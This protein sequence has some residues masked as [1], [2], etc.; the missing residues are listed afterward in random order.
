MVDKLVILGVL[1]FVSGILCRSFIFIPWS[2]V[3]FVALLSCV[4]FLLYS[5]RRAFLYLCIAV[6]L[7]GT[8]VGLARTE[9]APSDLPSVFGNLVGTEQS[10]EGRVITAPDV[11]ETSNRI[12]VEI[13]ED[14]IRTRLLAVAPLYPEVRL[15]DRV[16]VSGIIERPE[17]FTTN[18]ERVFNYDQFLIKEGIFLIIQ[19]AHL[20]V[21]EQRSGWW[22]V[23]GAPAEVKSGFIEALG[24]AL[25]EPH[26]SLASGL[27]AGGKQGL[28]GELLD[29]FT[30][31]GL[32]HLVVLSGYNVM[33]VAEAVLL[34][35]GFLSRT[36]AATVAGMAIGFFVIAAGA[37]P[38]SIRAGLMAGIGLYA[39]ATHRTY[40]VMR[41]LIAAFVFMLLWNPYLLAYDPGFQLSFIATLGLIF[42]APLIEPRLTFVRPVFVRSMIAATLAAQIAVLPLLLFSTGLLSLISVP[43]N[44]LVLPVVPLAMAA[45]ALAGLFGFI[46]PALAPIL[47]LPAYVFLTYIIEVARFTASLPGAYLA[48][49][50]FSWLLVPLAYAVIVIQVMKEHRAVMLRSALLDQ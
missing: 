41:A 21:V 45:S 1:G 47:A 25:P 12:V 5:F 15:G 17:P 40:I 14:G 27:V 28:G 16:R 11:R 33:I 48:L 13:E 10:V 35:L 19:R 30:Y 7:A 8:M 43:A 3:L 44:I 34:S 26:A 9:L 29:A 24:I 46:V 37:G 38:A 6:V 22:H 20:D 49:P 2:A 39:R 50:A 32:V 23:R 18:T 42:L 4:L 36:A 31:T